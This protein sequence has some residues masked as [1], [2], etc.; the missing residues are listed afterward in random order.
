[1]GFT[2]AGE[3]T[4]QVRS[5]LRARARRQAMP[6]AAPVAADG[7]ARTW[8]PLL[9][10]DVTRPV[11][12]ANPA[13]VAGLSISQVD[14]VVGAGLGA[15][16]QVWSQAA[17]GHAQL[18]VLLAAYRV[19]GLAEGLYCVAGSRRPPVS[20]ESVP[21]LAGLQDAYGGTPAI[22]LICANPHQQ[23]T[24]ENGCS[25]ASLLVRAG[26]LAYG[27]HLAASS[28][29][30]AC[31]TYGRSSYHGTVAAGLWDKGNRHFASV[32]VGRDELAQERR[33]SAADSALGAALGIR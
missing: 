9:T 15:E 18:V 7:G 30:L 22:L 17:H 11:K 19:A 23:F 1:M 33:P 14:D 24:I 10:A 5:L 21:L 25:Y 28:M 12:R 31:T 4:R 16:G 3:A 2:E 32:A 13:D 8:Q 26:T 29:G 20:S 27:M 6:R